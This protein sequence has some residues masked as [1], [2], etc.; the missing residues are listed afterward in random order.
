MASFVSPLPPAASF[1][2]SVSA[3]LSLPSPVFFLSHFSAFVIF[4]VTS[5]IAEILIFTSSTLSSGLLAW[6]L[7]KQEGIFGFLF[8]F[9]TLLKQL[10]FGQAHLLFHFLLF[11]ELPHLESSSLVLLFSSE[12]TFFLINSPGSRHV[13]LS[14]R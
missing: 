10:L 12:L 4:A 8:V 6:D 13:I 14:L 9:L 3:P 2:L 7:H 11:F 1:S 5:R